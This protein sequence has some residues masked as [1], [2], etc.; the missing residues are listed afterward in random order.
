MPV[1]AWVHAL[2]RRA[3]N[4]DSST[5]LNGRIR[6]FSEQAVGPG[7]APVPSLDVENC[8]A[9]ECPATL[10]SDPRPQRGNEMIGTAVDR[11]HV[12]EKLGQ[13]GI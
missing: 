8:V 6:L 4:D 9:A 1:V 12:V 11:Y 3:K 7:R 5:L 10:H 13:G 2:G